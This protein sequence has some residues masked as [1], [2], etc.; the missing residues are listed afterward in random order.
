MTTVINY[1]EHKYKT[2]KIEDFYT[3]KPFEYEIELDIPINPYFRNH[4][5]HLSSKSKMLKWSRCKWKGLESYLNLTSNKDFYERL[6][7]ECSAG[8]VRKLRI[9]NIYY[10][11]KEKEKWIDDLNR[12][13][14]ISKKIPA[15]SPIF[16]TFYKQIKTM[17]YHK[18]YQKVFDL[19]K[20]RFNGHSDEF[21][22]FYVSYLR[23]MQPS[24]INTNKNLNKI[25]INL[26]AKPMKRNE[27]KKAR[28]PRKV[29][30]QKKLNDPFEFSI[31][32]YT[33]EK[34]EVLFKSSN[35]LLFYNN[36]TFKDVL[37]T[38]L[39]KINFTGNIYL[40]KVNKWGTNS[41]LLKKEKKYYNFNNLGYKSK[42][43][44]VNY[45]K[46]NHRLICIQS[47]N[48]PKDIHRIEKYKVDKL[49][50]SGLW[51]IISKEDYKRLNGR[52]I[53][54]DIKPNI[55]ISK[56]VNPPN[57]SPFRKYVDS[58]GDITDI[59]VINRLYRFVNEEV[60]KDPVLEETKRR[61]AILER[62]KYKRL[63]S[64][65]SKSSIKRRHIR[66]NKSH[67]E[68]E[69][70]YPKY[71]YI[72]KLKYKKDTK[73]YEKEL[74]RIEEQKLHDKIRH[75]IFI[76]R[77]EFKDTTIK[78]VH[79]PDPKIKEK[80]EKKQKKLRSHATLMSVKKALRKEIKHNQKFTDDKSKD[81]KK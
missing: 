20:D 47:T 22:Q 23:W 11:H 66:T 21:I 41:I 72:D 43:N 7:N 49:I 58:A 71:S 29:K 62:E 18:S 33:K 68:V 75:E 31:V 38:Q 13:H 79:T 45:G 69:V 8:R 36:D 51:Q 55:K 39:N 27:I 9:D 53:N 81:N 34:I 61:V 17:L 1:E 64:L 76:K 42:L 56:R 57:G 12:L 3:T 28:L 40:V 52:A 73:N 2:L 37:N 67:T 6:K 19:L 63:K 32:R 35:G 80:W 78:K 5:L 30:K 74:K 54:M 10:K 25:K 70:H 50:E 46:G 4:T 48:N 60:I 44:H 15:T 14:L 26:E 16:P 77:L 24:F 59:K 65:R